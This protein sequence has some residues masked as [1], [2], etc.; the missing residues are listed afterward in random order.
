MS[1][2]GKSTDTAAYKVL[3]HSGRRGAQWRTVYHGEDWIKA[4]AEYEWIKDALRQGGVRFLCGDSILR[5]C[6]APRLRSKW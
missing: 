1:G 3:R 6:S 5:A 2:V 4:E